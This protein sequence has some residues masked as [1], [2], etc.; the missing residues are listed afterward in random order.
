MS[1]NRASRSGRFL[2]GDIAGNGLSKLFL[3]IAGV[4]SMLKESS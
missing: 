3:T 4:H 2:G 1:D